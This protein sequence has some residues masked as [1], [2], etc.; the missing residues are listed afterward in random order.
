MKLTILKLCIAALLIIAAGIFVGY[1][2]SVPLQSSACNR[3]AGVCSVYLQKTRFSPKIVENTFE[4][5]KMTGYKL[6][7][8]QVIISNKAEN[9]KG[10][11]FKLVINTKN[12][13][14]AIDLYT[15]NLYESTQADDFINKIRSEDMF[16]KRTT[17]IDVL[18]GE[19]FNI[20]HSK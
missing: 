16:V 11:R 8:R 9:L 15:F 12:P 5:A 19:L 4:I 6:E 18:K 13:E 2:Y 3:N 7:R 20:I 10:N 14:K 17:L 1:L